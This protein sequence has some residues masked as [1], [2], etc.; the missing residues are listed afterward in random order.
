MKAFPLQIGGIPLRKR[1]S[2]L[3]KMLY[4]WRCYYLPEVFRIPFLLGKIARPR[5]SPFVRKGLLPLDRHSRERNFPS[6]RNPSPKE[7]SWR[8]LPRLPLGKKEG[9]RGSLLFGGGP[10]FWRKPPFWWIPFR[11][12]T[13]REGKRQRSLLFL[14][15]SFLWKRSTLKAVRER[16]PSRKGK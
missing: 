11:K 1:K 14:R 4:L 9:L 13:G 7:A 5:K 3:G 12:V 8:T 10:R 15:E 6:R 2:S 16:V